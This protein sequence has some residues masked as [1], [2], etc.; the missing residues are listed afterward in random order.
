[1]YWN[2]RTKRNK[3]R[4]QERTYNVV[5]ALPICQENY[6]PRGTVGGYNEKRNKNGSID[7]FWRRNLVNRSISS[8]KELNNSISSI[9]F[10]QKCN[11]DIYPKPGISR[12]ILYNQ[13]SFQSKTN[14]T[15]IIKKT[16]EIYNPIKDKSSRDFS[17]SKEKSYFI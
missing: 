5:Q 14:L 10:S 8:K 3:E 4:S 11:P 17:Q 1:M 13:N 16:Y 12:Y 6:K 9:D 2:R 7:Y 15:K